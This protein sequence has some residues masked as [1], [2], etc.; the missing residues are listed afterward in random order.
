MYNIE[1]A[2]ISLYAFIQTYIEKTD[3]KTIS[4]INSVLIAG[5]TNY[6]FLTDK[7]FTIA[8]EF[9]ESELSPTYLYTAK[10]LTAYIVFDFYYSLFPLK[11]DL[12][13]HACLLLVSIITVKKYHLQHL[14][15]LAMI[16]QTSSTFLTFIN[17][18]VICKYLFALTFFIYRI[19]I[20]PYLTT[21]YGIS[22]QDIIFTYPPTANT[23][24]F[25]LISTV[26]VL[27]FYWF[28]KII[29]K[30]YRKL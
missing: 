9:A 16:M 4:T 30:V 12:L 3:Y 20:F 25:I 14:L 7:N 13:I 19:C 24:I 29:R 5:T 23:I 8:Y 17:E 2:L 6:L 1:I 10:F 18:S 11:K 15:N 22:R 26:N 21:R 28:R 27:N